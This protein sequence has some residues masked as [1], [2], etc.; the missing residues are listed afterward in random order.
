MSGGTVFPQ[1]KMLLPNGELSSPWRFYFQNL[2]LATGG[3]TPTVPA[4]KVTVVPTGSISTADA[5]SALA[6]LDASKVPTIRTVNGH[7]LNADITV[8]ASDVGGV[9]NTRTVNGHPLS[10]NVT[11][12]A[13]DVGAPSGSGTSSGTN[14][15]DQTITLSGDASGSGTAGVAVTVSKIG[16]KAVSLAGALTT[17]GAFASTFT[18]TGVTAVT[19]P[20]SGTLATLAGSET[21]TNKTL[22]SPVVSGGSVNNTPIGAT[23]PSTGKFTT[24]ESTGYVK[25]ASTTVASLPAAAT[26]A[27]TRHFVTDATAATFLSIVAGGGANKVPVVSDGTNWLIG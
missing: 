13:A 26:G 16:G 20:T 17:A 5:Q 22:T 19:F 1:A 6:G 23:T 10:A 21:L 27:G 18:M 2:Y 9:P 15:G 3:G 14:T 25:S 11:V 4:S 12:T 7:P 24:L 8:T